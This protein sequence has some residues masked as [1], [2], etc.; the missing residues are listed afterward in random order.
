LNLKVVVEATTKCT[1]CTKGSGNQDDA[2]PHV[3][4][5]AC[6]KCRDYRSNFTECNSTSTSRLIAGSPAPDV[7]AALAFDFATEFKVAFDPG[8]VE[9]AE[10]VH[11]RKPYQIWNGWRQRSPGNLAKSR[12]VVASSHPVSIA[13]A[14]RYASGT[15]LP[16]QF[17][18]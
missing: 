17:P 10:T 4:A 3:I 8:V 16:R 15:K 9:D 18:S 1:K 11:D 5:E 14:A 12:S 6:T 13:R 7:A 2:R